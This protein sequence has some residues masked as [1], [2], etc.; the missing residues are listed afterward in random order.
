MV[1]GELPHP[2]QGE[3][4]VWYVVSLRP[5]IS[6]SATYNEYV[7]CGPRLVCS[8]DRNQ[9]LANPL[10]SGCGGVERVR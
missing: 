10:L 4:C 2:Q 8:V 9:L 3:E 7:V 6:T 1:G 5:H